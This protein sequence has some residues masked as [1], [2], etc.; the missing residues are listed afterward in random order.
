MLFAHDT[1]CSLIAAAALVNTAGRDGELLPDIAALDAFFVR[2]GYSGRHEQTEA[3]LRAVRELRPQLRR[4]W[5]SEPP[6]IV[7]LVNGLLLEHRALPQ[8]IEHDGE[9]YHLHA[10]PR[11]APLATRI[12]VEA[13]MAMADLVRARELSR[14]RICEYPDCD[15]VLVD[16]SRNRS[17]RF[18]E[19][20][21]GNRAAVTA[22]RARRA[23]GRS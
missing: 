1:E 4:I 20:G 3:E 11:D 2:R 18:C 7:A 5:Y 19:A 15:N 9:P 16:L 6:E 8:L 13:A 23:A 14:L 17:R 12:A 22:Y 21:C 10:V